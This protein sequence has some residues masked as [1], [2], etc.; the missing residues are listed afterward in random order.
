MEKA[1][2]DMAATKLL[3]QHH[4]YTE[5][6]LMKFL[7]ENSS[8]VKPAERRALIIGA[9]AG[10]RYAA[11]SHYTVLDNDREQFVT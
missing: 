7:E 8:N 6:G 5:P 9:A 2:L 10:A 4:R 3:V 11:M 1:G